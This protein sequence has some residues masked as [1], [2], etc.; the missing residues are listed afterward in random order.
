MF[1][2][3]SALLAATP[4]APQSIGEVLAGMRAMD[5]LFL[6]GDGLRWFH[7]LYL[8]VTE[9]VAARLAGGGFA[10]GTW[11]ADLDV[12]FAGLYFDALRRQL[13]GQAAPGCWRALLDRRADAPVA[14]I[15]FALAGVNAH[16]NHD[17]P[18]A[19]V[20][21]C[22]RAGTAPRHGATEYAD[23]TAVNATLNTLIDTAK[24]ELMV[25]LLGDPLPAVSH[26]EDRLAA[27][28]VSAAREAAWTNG[29]VMW[30][31]GGDRLLASRFEGMLDG[32]TAVAG[33]T[34]M[35]PVPVA[36]A[37]AG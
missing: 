24:A 1:P 7:R 11:L 36:L 3:D 12:Q 5:A 6:D 22:R 21:T 2:Y 23:Y 4:S 34:L 29:E 20:A 32:L 19:I 14:R 15:Q 30:G 18:F 28:S 17:L 25:R 9:A 33:K 37:Q 26:L 35:A 31:I 16:I 13:S 8:Q 27:W 10:N